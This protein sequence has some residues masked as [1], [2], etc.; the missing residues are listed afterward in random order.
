MGGQE[1]WAD[2]TLG[3]FQSILARVALEEAQPIYQVCP[4]MFQKSEQKT[5]PPVVQHYSEW[6]TVPISN[7]SE[8]DF[9]N[10]C[11]FWVRC[12]RSHCRD[13]CWTPVLSSTPILCHHKGGIVFGRRPGQTV[14][15]PIMF[16]KVSLITTEGLTG[17]WEPELLTEWCV[18]DL[19][20]MRSG[21]CN[22]EYEYASAHALK[23]LCF[24]L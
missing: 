15:E 8:Q 2:D 6:E 9:S 20:S 7:S 24:Q 19:P 21:G 16:G 1:V 23:W 14:L 12:V 10:V 5:V 17:R 11:V 3:L 13:S 18:Q 22:M 4:F